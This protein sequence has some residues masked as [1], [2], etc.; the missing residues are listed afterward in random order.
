MFTVLTASY[1]DAGNGPAAPVTGT[2]EAILQPKLKQA[3]YWRDHGPHGRR[4][5]HR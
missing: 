5:R 4:S 3:E 2:A 1:T